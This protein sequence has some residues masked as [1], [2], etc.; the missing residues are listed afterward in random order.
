MPKMSKNELHFDPLPRP[1]VKT[2]P[3]AEVKNAPSEAMKL[4]T[5]KPQED[6]SELLSNLTFL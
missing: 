3:L 5:N 6:V 1:D 2:P 4:E